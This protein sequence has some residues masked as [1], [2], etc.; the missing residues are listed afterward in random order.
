MVQQ[1]TQ[2]RANLR[3]LK[4][5]PQWQVKRPHFAIVHMLFSS[6]VTSHPIR[7]NLLLISCFADILKEGELSKLTSRIV[8]SQLEEK[9]DVSFLGR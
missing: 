3:T 7:S 4:F 8:R 2:W 9:F 6:S 5:S 1:Q